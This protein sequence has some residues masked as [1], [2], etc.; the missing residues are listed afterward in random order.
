MACNINL[1]TELLFY[2]SW[3]S[4]IDSAFFQI[5]LNTIHGF[6]LTWSCWPKYLKALPCQCGACIC[7]FGDCVVH[8]GEKTPG[9]ECDKY[10]DCDCK[11]TPDKCFCEYGYCDK[12]RWE[13]HETDDCKKM[14]KCDGKNCVCASTVF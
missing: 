10:T 9:S 12:S 7:L 6:P 2:F 4:L 13:C 14:D 1:K 3:I 8:M 5:K 11:D